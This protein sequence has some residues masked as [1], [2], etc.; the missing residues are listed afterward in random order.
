M[1]GLLALLGKDL[2]VLR[3]SPGL[4]AVLAAYPLLLA[5]LVAVV[6]HEAGA[7]PRVAF[8]DEAPLPHSIRVGRTIVDVRALLSDVGERVDLER[9][10]ASEAAAALG[11][12][13]VVASITVPA[14]FVTDIRSTV[15]SAA[16]TLATRDSTVGQR[17]AREAQAF[18]AAL[19]G[20]VQRE[21]LRQN[22][23]Y[24]ELLVTGGRTSVLGREVEI[25]GLDRTAAIVREQQARA[26][27]EDERRRL[28][29]VVEFA[30]EARLALGLA[31]ASLAATARPVTLRE[32]RVGGRAAL[33]ENRAV[34][35]V[36]AVGLVLAGTLVGAGAVASEREENAIGRLVRGPVRLSTLVAG[37]VLLVAVVSI[38]LGLLVVAAFAA[39]A[40]P[41]GL[42]APAPLRVLPLAVVLA[43]A[44]AAIGAV[45]VLIG[46]VVGD[47][48]AGVLVA[49][50]V[51][52]PFVLAGLVPQGVAP[53]LDVVSALFPFRPA[54]DALAAV[55][56]DA[57]PLGDVLRGGLH[58]AALAAVFAAGARLLAH[59]LAR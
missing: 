39:A 18:V 25:V 53:A 42:D 27:S 45:G 21:L 56:Y 3:R 28:G 13:D 38:V 22:V 50:L 26:T 2:R 55:L 4:L 41:L 47:F 40:A 11:R 44:G 33:L 19:N 37:K 35:I 7:R 58:L 5:G 20:A 1:T 30:R 36:L 48:A 52:L 14:G 9:M 16:V 10:T 51:T 34:A 12:G 6:T 17:A 24:L 8:V 23:S 46:V 32:R 54:V 31:D 15:R 57:D 59:R 43:L 49:L 29:E